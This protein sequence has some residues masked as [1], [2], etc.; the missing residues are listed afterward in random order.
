[1]KIFRSAS[2]I[3]FIVLTLASCIGF[4]MRILEPKDFMVL[5]TSAFTFYFS[6]K[7]DNIDKSPH[8]DK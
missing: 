5:V 7:N 8:N 3:A 2:K 6:N 1:M 4:F